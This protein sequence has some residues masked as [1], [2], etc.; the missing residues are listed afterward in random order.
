MNIINRLVERTVRNYIRK[1]MHRR[2]L[3]DV[4]SLIH[5]EYSHVYHEDNIPTRFDYLAELINETAPISYGYSVKL[6]KEKT[7]EDN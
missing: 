7:D 3:K 4:F 2:K 5:E 6:V 1:Q